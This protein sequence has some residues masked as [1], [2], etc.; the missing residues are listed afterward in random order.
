[1]AGYRIGNRD[2]RVEHRGS[3]SAW[4]MKED[5]DEARW[6]QPSCRRYFTID[7]DDRV[8]FYSHSELDK[9]IADP[10]PFKE[11]LWASLVEVDTNANLVKQQRPVF[12]VETCQRRIRLV[13]ESAADAHLWIDA[14]NAARLIGQ[15]AESTCKVGL[16]R[17]SWGV[18]A[19]SKGAASIASASTADGS[20]S[21][22]S[23]RSGGSRMG[24]SSAGDGSSNRCQFR[25]LACSP[26]CPLESHLSETNEVDHRLRLASPRDFSS[27]AFDNAEADSD[28][29]DI[30]LQELQDDIDEFPITT[31]IPSGIRGHRSSADLMPSDFGLSMCD[32]PRLDAALQTPAIDLDVLEVLLHNWDA[33]DADPVSLPPP[34][35]DAGADTMW[36]AYSR[37][38]RPA[39]I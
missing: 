27:D 38:Q 32:S 12:V 23:S 33:K 10:I 28:I 14:L 17:A 39:P 34:S 36:A 18:R 25:S 6:F 11:I 22:A 13:S 3:Y 5:G 4:L 24:I 9:Y 21:S 35:A 31:P 29:L 2:A 7:F 8:I 19:P 1:M 16:F 30:L 15:Q 20:I 26:P 37:L